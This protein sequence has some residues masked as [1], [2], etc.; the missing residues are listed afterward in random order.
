MIAEQV[1]AGKATSVG[2]GYFDDDPLILQAY[3]S[4]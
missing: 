2:E 3:Q 1:L 4:N